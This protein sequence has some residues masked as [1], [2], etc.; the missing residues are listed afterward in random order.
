MTKYELTEIMT[1]LFRGNVGEARNISERVI[2]DNLCGL[3]E[4][5]ATR[6]NKLNYHAARLNSGHLLIDTR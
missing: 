6:Q 2:Y 1:S 4:D 3:P 5:E